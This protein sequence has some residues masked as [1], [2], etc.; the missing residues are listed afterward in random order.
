MAIIKVPKTPKKAFN[1]QRPPSELLKQQIQHLEWAVR[2][3]SQRKP[4]MIKVRGVRTEGE[5]ADR[6]QQLTAQLREQQ[7]APVTVT[8]D[9]A[10]P[11]RAPHTKVKRRSTPKPAGKRTGRRPATAKKKARSARKT[12]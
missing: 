3:A 7:V 8:P 10:P 12:R 2:P 6:I 11:A 5:A 4:G 1:A 9:I